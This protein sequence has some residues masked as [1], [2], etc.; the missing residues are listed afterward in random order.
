M[1]S[2]DIWKTTP[3]EEGETQC[4]CAWCKEDL[5]YDDEYWELD[6]EIL[7]E[8]CARDWLNYRRNWVSASMARGE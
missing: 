6:G 1:D 8:D 2:Y 7:C 5:F 4:H 3:P